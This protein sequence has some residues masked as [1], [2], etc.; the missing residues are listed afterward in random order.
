MTVHPFPIRRTLAAILISL[1]GANSASAI[2]LMQAYQDALENDPAYR[3][4]RFE[5]EAG[6]E[7]RAI[8]RSSLMPNLSMSYATNRNFLN[9]TTMTSQGN[10]TTQPDYNGV[11]STLSLR[12][13]L[14]N[15]GDLA[16]YHEGVAQAE[17]SSAQFNGRG[18]ELVIRLVSA[19]TDAL[20]AEDQLALAN[21]QRDAFE[22]QKL[23]N[24]RMM[25]KGEG[26]KTDE[27]ET[28]SKY[29]MALAQ[30]I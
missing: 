13:P 20:Y 10:F 3:S 4:A 5:N 18:Q 26:T 30:V 24:E 16:R 22:E 8:G 17:Y 14:F 23:V 15:M 2:G 9:M 7:N 28:E 19:Y 29:A 6:Q 25:Q 21:A 27:L 11:V 12:Q 1:I